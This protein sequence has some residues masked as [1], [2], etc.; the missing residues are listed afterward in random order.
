MKFDVLYL[1]S[2]NSKVVFAQSAALTGSRPHR[3]QPCG[4]LSL[5]HFSPLMDWVTRGG[6]R[7]DLAETQFQSFL[8]EA[9]VSNSCMGMST[10]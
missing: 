5:V 8:Q 3:F 2:V 10:F 4:V 7:D 6:T 1:V 9:L